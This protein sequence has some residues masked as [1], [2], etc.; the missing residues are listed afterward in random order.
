MKKK[1]INAARIRRVPD[2][3]SWVDHRL[4]RQYLLV[5]C[6]THSWALYLFLVTV[7]DA[8]G[9]SYYSDASVQRHISIT[10]TELR[11]A[12]G[13]LIKAGLIA[14]EAP[15]YQVLDLESHST[16]PPFSESKNSG[17]TLEIAD[18]LGNLLKGG[19]KR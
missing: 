10:A 14:W 4:I 3:F 9:I 7:A 1:I 19:D 11:K 8:D 12:R 6:S 5:G 17:E 15:F 2:H 13:E 18:I 16:Q